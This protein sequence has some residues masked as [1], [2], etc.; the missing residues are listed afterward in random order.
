MK[1]LISLWLTAALLCTFLCSCGTTAAVTAI[2]LD[3]SGI[4]VN[5]APASQQKSKAVYTAN[6]IVYYEQG[7]DFTYGEGD[8]TDAHSAEEANRH[9]V[10]HIQKA[11]TY[12]LSGTLSAGQIA[13]DLGEDADD[14]PSDVVTLILDNVNLTCTVAPAIIFYNVYECCDND[15]DTAT[16]TVDT[17]AAGANIVLA[18]GSQNTV[19]G[20]YVAKIYESYT[21]ND[22]GTEV[23]DSDKL[24]KYDGA[25][26]S[27][28]TMNVSG[29]KKGN[30]TL[31]ITAQNEGLDSERH[32]TL[33]GGT[34]N[35]VSENDGINTNEDGI[36]VTTV[37]GGT[38]NITVSP[39]A[40]E[41]DGIDS[42]GW[43]VING[44]TV[45]AFACGR[46]MDSGIDSDNGI[47]LNGG[48]IVATGNMLDR[49]ANGTQTFAVF[50]F[51]DSQPADT[52][53]TLKNEQGETV[54][55][56]TPANTFTQLV[57]SSPTLKAGTYTLYRGE[58]ALSVA[59]TNNGGGRP[60]GGNR[61]FDNT[62]EP[63]FDGNE[64]P[65]KPQGDFGERPSFGSETPPEKPEGE[66][67]PPFNG[68]EPPQKPE[69]GFG[70]RPTPPAGITNTDT[71]YT[72][73]FTLADGA[74]YFSVAKS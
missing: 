30:G 32:L 28:M 40:A 31:T 57:I 36:S 18:D 7:R 34:V 44:G 60:Q 72:T 71:I 63:P 22:A 17:K 52:V 48:T 12:R 53:Y 13:V 42:N 56:T 61:P 11:G 62:N 74:N 1:N 24:H 8:E 38:L 47:F 41:G 39:T 58:T 59:T 73:T 10:V 50:A 69:G 3:D 35:I 20:S 45:N 43:L 14:K 54:V 26:Y 70:E 51:A 68:N 49:L 6:D 23:T 5:G 4:T 16:Q 33:N 2:T 27:C 37:N 64:P 25:V 46:S 19:N 66:T 29:E 65:Q 67:P 21:L 9:T 15:E 55:S